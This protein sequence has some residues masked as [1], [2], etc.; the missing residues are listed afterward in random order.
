MIVGKSKLRR[1]NDSNLKGNVLQNLTRNTSNVKKKKSLISSSVRK[2]YF[3]N[4]YAFHI[5]S[6]LLS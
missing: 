5:A 3:K 4:T 1:W 6:R 2:C